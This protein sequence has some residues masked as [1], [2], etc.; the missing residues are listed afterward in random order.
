MTN[1]QV[2]DKPVRGLFDQS[3]TAG[4]YRIIAPA[5]DVLEAL[6]DAGWQAAELVEA[7]DKAEFL[8]LVGEALGFP[9]HYGQNL[10]ALWDCLTDLRT[11]TALVWTGWSKLAIDHGHDWAMIMELLRGRTEQKPPFALILG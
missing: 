5:E 10:D 3:H 6:R 9:A 11:P 8:A 7:T 1:N 2:P 4:V